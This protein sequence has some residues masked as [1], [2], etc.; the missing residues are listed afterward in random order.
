M[1]DES[2]RKKHRPRQSGV[3]ADK[4]RKRKLDGDSKQRNPKA[5]A[6]QSAN[7][8]ARIVRR[9]LDRATKKEHIPYVNRAPDEPPP[10][11]VAVVGPPKVGKTTLIRGL[12]R[13]YSKQAVTSIEGPVT[14]V[15][16]KKKRITFVECPNDVSAMIDVAKVADLVKLLILFIVH[17]LQHVFIRFCCWLMLALGSR[18]KFLNF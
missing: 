3:K 1:D 17:V 9:N 13:H 5:F 4:K 12:V 14:L 18:W 8:A 16:G 10:I 2:S 6:I 15:S 7:K 11:V